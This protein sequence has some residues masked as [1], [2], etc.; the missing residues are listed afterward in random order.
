M[1]SQVISIWKEI[2]MTS[3]DVV[4]IIKK[5]NKDS[6]VGHCGTLDPFADGVILICTGNETKNINN[7]MDLKK[8]YI[9]DIVFGCETDTLDNTGSIIKKQSPLSSTTSI[10][11]VTTA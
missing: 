1:D 10:A 11:F 5:K 9:A 3:Y 6:K 8:E 4:S 7:L 2:G